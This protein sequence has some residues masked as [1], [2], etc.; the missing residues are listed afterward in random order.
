MHNYPMSNEVN[1]PHVD[2]LPCTD[3]G[4]QCGTAAR[5]GAGGQ[6]QDVHNAF[7]SPSM[8]NYAHYLLVQL[9]L[10]HCL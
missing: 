1:T 6:S 10:S 7:R 3:H 9:V 5:R 8:V 4:S 2:T